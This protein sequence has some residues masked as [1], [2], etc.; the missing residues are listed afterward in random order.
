MVSKQNVII[1]HCTKAHIDKC[2]AGLN[3]KLKIKVNK[4]VQSKI[5]ILVKCV[6]NE[7]LTTSFDVCF[8]LVFHSCHFPLRTPEGSIQTLT[9]HADQ[10]L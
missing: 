9:L 1:C 10:Y 3:K 5:K 7:S 8:I 6:F 4:L 2:Y